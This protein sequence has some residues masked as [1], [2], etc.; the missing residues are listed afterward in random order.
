MVL[1]LVD[2]LDDGV[3]DDRRKALR[4]LVDKEEGGV[5]HNSPGNGEH[6][7]LSP[8]QV[9]R[10]ALPE[11]PEIG[12]H[13]QGPLQPLGRCFI[14]HE[15][16]H[17]HIFFHRKPSEDPHIFR[18]KA[19]PH[20]GDLIGLLLLDFLPLKKDFPLRGRKEADDGPQSSALARPV[21]T[22]KHRHRIGL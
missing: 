3:H 1:D 2:G 8:A 16:G 22:D 19:D 12:K 18:D 21:T 6:L 20:P 14:L 9:S 15:H 4:G 5:V 17:P 11:L 7:F 13:I 10:F